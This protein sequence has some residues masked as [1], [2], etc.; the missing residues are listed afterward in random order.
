M[1]LANA[2][3]FPMTEVGMGRG[4]EGGQTDVLSTFNFVGARCQASMAPESLPVS[5]AQR[6]PF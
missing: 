2:K 6:P 1:S 5:A 4:G 3:N